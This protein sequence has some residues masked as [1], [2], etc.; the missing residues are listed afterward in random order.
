M[1]SI[2]SSFYY[3]HLEEKY[4]GY[5]KNKKHGE[6]NLIMRLTDD[7]LIMSSNLQTINSLLDNL[8]QCG[9][10]NAFEFNDSKLTTNFSYI[11]PYKKGKKLEFKSQNFN[12]SN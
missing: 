9:K 4:I 12:S 5:I 3:A 1:S 7:Y 8:F 11:N 6:L 2:I 10:E